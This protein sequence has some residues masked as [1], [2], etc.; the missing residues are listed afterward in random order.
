M[1]VRVNTGAWASRSDVKIVISINPALLYPSL[2]SKYPANQ[3]STGAVP[4]YM[5]AVF[6]FDFSQPNNYGQWQVTVEVRDVATGNL[7]Q[8]LPA[9]NNGIFII[10]GADADWYTVQHLDHASV[11]AA[12]K[13]PDT[14]NPILHRT[15]T[16]SAS[17]MIS[18]TSTSGVINDAGG[19]VIWT[20]YMDWYGQPVFAVTY[21]G[22][23]VDVMYDAITPLEET[24]TYDV[25]AIT[26]VVTG[27]DHSETVNLEFFARYQIDHPAVDTYVALQVST[28][29]PWLK[30]ETSD[31]K[32]TM[33]V[34]VANP[35]GSKPLTWTIRAWTYAV[36]VTSPTIF[37]NQ[38]ANLE[39]DHE[40]YTATVVVDGIARQLGGLSVNVSIASGAMWLD[41]NNANATVTI[42]NQAGEAIAQQAFIITI[43]HG[44][45]NHYA[46]LISGDYA[47]GTYTVEIVLTYNDTSIGTTTQQLPAS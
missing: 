36:R 28:G 20:P 46:W 19:I 13:W 41:M 32:A 30:T 40:D 12:L 8:T 16:I 3:T 31:G 22:S 27:Q 43:F 42:R 45:V 6:P 21:T 23:N 14:G 25:L 29:Q 47:P 44:Q 2:L 15:G 10:E 26:Y 34:S 18:T 9:L 24:F 4:P 7:I 37:A 1:G 35:D 5:T 33:A 38:W 11:V 39:V 17:G